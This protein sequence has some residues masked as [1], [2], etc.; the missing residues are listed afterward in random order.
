MADRNSAEERE[1][2]KRVITEE[3]PICSWCRHRPKNKRALWCARA[4]DWV[5][6]EAMD[7]R[8]CDCFELR[9]S[10]LNSGRGGN[11]PN[12]A[13]GNEQLKLNFEV[14]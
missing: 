5:D 6:T 2:V 13:W 14:E 12:V 10:Y 4:M 1:Y 3:R 8:Q 7:R 11:A 9:E